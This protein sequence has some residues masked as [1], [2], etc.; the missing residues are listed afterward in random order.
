MVATAQPFGHQ[1]LREG[2]L[3]APRLHGFE[4]AERNEPLRVPYVAHAAR[5]ARGIVVH[6]PFVERYLRAFGCKTPIFVAPHP[7]IESEPRVRKAE[8]AARVIRGSLE[9]MGMQTL[10]GVFGDQNAAKLIDVVLEA[11]V[12]LPQDVHLGVMTGV[13]VPAGDAYPGFFDKVA[14]QLRKLDACIGQFVDY[15]KRADLYDDSIVILTADHGDLYGADGRWGHAN[16]LYP[17]VM[18]VPLIVRVPPRLRTGLAADLGEVAFLTDITPTLYGLLGYTPTDLGPLFGR[19]LFADADAGAPSRRGDDFLVASAYGAVYGVV[20][21][22]G[23]RMYVVDTIEGREYLQDMSGPSARSI[24]VTPA[25][26][27]A[28]RA[29]IRRDIDRLSALYRFTP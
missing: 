25:I 27:A 19:P 5:N 24:D 18:R 10:I 29:L 1:A 17:D 23:R 11:M 28:H 20:R 22:N 15:L 12:H 13:D 14:F 7:V 8:G 4:E 9:S 6:S 26:A 16:L 2:L 21:Q 3:L